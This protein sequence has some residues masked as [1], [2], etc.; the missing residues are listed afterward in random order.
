MASGRYYDKEGYVRLK[1]QGKLVG[2]HRVVMENVVGRPLLSSE[3]VHHRNRV[4]DDNLPTNLEL[5]TRKLHSLHHALDRAV[6]KISLVC[7]V[8]FGI[9]ELSPSKY[10][11]QTKMGHV[12]HCSRRCVGKDCRKFVNGTAKPSLMVHG[13]SN[14]YGYHKC[15]CDKCRLFKREDARSRREKDRIG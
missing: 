1:V 4:K 9:F 3:L 10:R 11:Y 14:G 2:E 8:C 13:T 12:I 7:P 5:T 6:S 15:R